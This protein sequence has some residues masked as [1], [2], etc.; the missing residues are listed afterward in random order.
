ML[1]HVFVLYFSRGNPPP[2]QGTRA[3]LGDLD[4]N[5]NMENQQGR[6]FPN[7]SPHS[8]TGFAWLAPD[9][10]YLLDLT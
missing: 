2:K 1:V 4:V 8:S 6:T 7:S 5:P 9:L 10:P 3:L